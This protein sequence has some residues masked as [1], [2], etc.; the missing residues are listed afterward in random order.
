MMRPH[1]PSALV[2]HCITALFVVMFSGLSLRA[3]STGN[4]TDANEHQLLLERYC[5]TCHNEQLQTAGLNLNSLDISDVAAHPEVWEKV[6]HR[7][8]SRTM[9]PARRPRP[10]EHAYTAL[11]SWLETDPL[12]RL[13]EG[14]TK[15]E[16]SMSVYVVRL[17]ATVC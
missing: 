3:Q 16:A 1:R 8:R 10:D 9:P 14:Y 15:F 6:V 12:L 13:F 2:L 11:A 17:C 4:T 7:L 5:I